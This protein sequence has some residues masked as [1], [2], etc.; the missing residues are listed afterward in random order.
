MLRAKLKR[1]FN[2]V[3]W[4]QLRSVK[5]VSNV[6]GFDRGTP[7]DRYYIEKFLKQ[8]S[9][10][11][12]GDVLEIAS[13][14]YCKQFG[15]NIKRQHILHYDN[16]NPKA[17]IV[18]DLSNS[19]TLPANTID[20]FVCT[21]T[22]NFIYDFRKAIEGAHHLLKKDGVL[23]ATVAG[24]SQISRYDMDRWGDFWRF[25]TKSAEQAFADVFGKQ[26]VT[27]GQFGNVLSA[28]A[29]LQGISKEE[30]TEEELDVVDHDYQL[31]IT[32]VA[33]K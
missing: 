16:S 21:Q 27:I 2:P 8:N 25:T 24:L 12:A 31:I 11:I 7:V 17:T 32:I 23:L 20:C 30:L 5:P 4:H 3:R 9:K 15:S 18:G 22:F 29:L 26:N 1:L 28:T 19:S 33:R 14:D 13:D 10:L 6:F